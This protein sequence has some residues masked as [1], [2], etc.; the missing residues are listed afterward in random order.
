MNRS[1]ISHIDLSV[2]HFVIPI[3]RK[4]YHPHISVDNFHSCW[5]S[6][7]LVKSIFTSGKWG[8]GRSPFQNSKVFFFQIVWMGARGAFPAALGFHSPLEAPRPNQSNQGPWSS[9]FWTKCWMYSENKVLWRTWFSYGAI[10]NNLKAG[11][12]FTSCSIPSQSQ[13][14]LYDWGTSI[15]LIPRWLVSVTI[16]VFP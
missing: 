16:D 10:K 15:Q 11:I 4:M 14:V 6:P 7:E 2:H 13:G 3:N 9:D 12:Q 1:I 5:S 8:C